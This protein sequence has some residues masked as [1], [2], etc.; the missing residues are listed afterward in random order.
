MECGAKWVP[1]EREGIPTMGGS[2][3][4]AREEVLASGRGGS[5]TGERVL[6]ARGGVPVASRV[7]PVQ[8][9]S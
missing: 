2:V 8:A 6:T 7:V 5:V 3:S 9:F 4:A 1:V